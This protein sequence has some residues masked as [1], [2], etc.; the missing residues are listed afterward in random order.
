MFVTPSKVFKI[1]LTG[2]GTAGHVMPHL[3]LLEEMKNRSWDVSYI[4]T[5]SIEKE[6]MTPHNIPFYTI[7]AGKLRRYFSIKNFFDIFRCF[8]GLLQSLYFLLKIKPDLVFSKGGYVSVPVCLA[9]WILRVPVVTHESDVTPGLANKIL[10]KIAIRIFY[11][12]P[13]SKKYL[14]SHSEYLRLPIR[15]EL[16]TGSKQRALDFCNF[17]EEDMRPVVLIMGGSQGS[18]SLN[19]VLLK[20]LDILLAKYRVIHITG[21]NKQTSYTNDGSYFQNEY[22]K[23]DLK[24][25]LSLADVVISR[26]G[27]NS[28]FEF[29][30]LSKPMVLIPLVQG[31]RGD[32]VV[33]ARCF[34]ENNWATLLF[35]SKLNSQDL[36]FA[37]D[38]EY[39][40]QKNQ[41]NSLVEQEQLQIENERAFLDKI[42]SYKKRK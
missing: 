17:K 4:G 22:V 15:K 16:F 35:E 28:I 27:A 37:I 36:F 20:S 25:L 40:E 8:W 10:M 41:E 12:F 21:K 32:Q 42:Y 38:K 29:L 23:E 9:A 6:L 18:V 39:S 3:A 5:Y 11:S 26:A 7:S 2:G 13:Q 1:V 30:A 33:N 31:S 24:D 34:V 19:E 14:P